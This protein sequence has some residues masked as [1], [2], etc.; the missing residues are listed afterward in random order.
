MYD[1]VQKIVLE[2]GALA[3]GYFSRLAT[4]GVES[5]GHLDL[6]TEAD[7]AVE[8]LI[9]RRLQEGFPDDG[10]YG[11]E[12]T[13]KPS[14]S[15]RTWVI[16]PIDGTFNFLRGGDRWAISIGLH[17]DRRPAFG[18]LYAPIRDQL[19]A[20]GSGMPSTLNGKTLSCRNGLDRDRAACAVGLHPSIAV[21]DQLAAIRFILDEARMTFRNSGCAVTDLIDVALG[22][23][24][25]YLGLGISTWDLMAIL[26]ILEQVG[27][28]TTID[29]DSVDLPQKLRFA[30]GTPEFLQV[31][32][33]APHDAARTV[34]G[35]ENQL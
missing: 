26:P 22:E 29:W 23:V 5:K 31:F 13:A 17:E 30:C 4:I 16:D 10:I 8:A 3:T 21:D 6:V 35:R 24:D 19:L 27:V 7:K 25:G 15:G 14:V 9:V 11:E 20:G 32:A 33:D 1:E 28:A 2:A 34:P 18:V 12:G